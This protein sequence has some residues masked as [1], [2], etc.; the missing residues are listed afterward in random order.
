M[1]SIGLGFK[2]NKITKQR[3]ETANR[4]R[5]NA[6]LRVRGGLEKEGESE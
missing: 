3:D 2:I 5:R 6:N 4:K 1:R